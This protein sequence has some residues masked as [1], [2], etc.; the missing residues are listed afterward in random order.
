MT[1]IIFDIKRDNGYG[2]EVYHKGSLIWKPIQ[3]ST[4][5]PKPSMS[6]DLGSGAIEFNVEETDGT[7]LWVVVENIFTSGGTSVTYER[8]VSVPKSDKPINY[9]DLPDEDPNKIFDT[10]ETP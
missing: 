6:F 10:A 4:T 5:H 1:K 9:L 7:F 2:K 3:N 8:T